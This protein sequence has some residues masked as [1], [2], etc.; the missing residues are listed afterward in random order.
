VLIKNRSEWHKE[1][2]VVVIGCGGAGAVSAITASDNGSEVVVIEKQPLG[3][4]MT[5]TG[6]SAGVF[7]GVKDVYQA[8]TYM[9]KLYRIENKLAWTGADILEVWAEYCASN[10]DWLK[11]IGGHIEILPVGAEH[12]F[13]GRESISVLRATGNGYALH[14]WLKNNLKTRNI[15][16]LY[17]TPAKK[18]LTN[19]NGE[20]IGVRAMRNGKIFNIKAI[21]A[22][23]MAPGG[24]EYDEE[25]KLNF[26]K[27]YPAYFTGSPANTGDGIRIV[28]DVG[29]SLWHMNC[30]SARAVAKF[31]GFPTAFSLDFGGTG[32]IKHTLGT[33][34]MPESC[35]FIIV[36]KYGRRYTNDGDIKSHTFYYELAYY[37]S[38]RLDYPRIPSYWIFDTNRMLRGPLVN[39]DTDP[40]RIYRFYRWSED[41]L[42]ELSR[43]WISQGDTLTEL[44]GKIGVEAGVLIKTVTN[45][46]SY[47]ATGSDSEFSRSER[48]LKPLKDPPFFAV[49]LWPGGPNTQGGPRRNKK[50]QVLN[51][52]G[53]PIPRLYAAGEF[54]SIYGQLYPS[55]GGNIAECLAFG[56]ISGEN[57][58]RESLRS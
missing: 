25:L 51:A 12:D 13:P 15:D 55:A 56:R 5:N 38:R 32:N 11:G 2:D 35:P 9:K 31:P 16:V 43:G 45:Y 1:A 6:M 21:K 30:C 8:V 41:N 23:I 33:E 22:V 24:F 57:A 18:L 46:N 53:N 28:Q 36:D 47:C 10:A 29:A 48:H 4:H 19:I 52:D 26:L 44:A 50:G 3:T 27:V 17:E 7:V 14:R 37:D 49:Q 58:S 54:G 20:V 39:P 34:K 40:A 42:V